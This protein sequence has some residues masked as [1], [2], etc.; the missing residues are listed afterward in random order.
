MESGQGDAIT[1]T[2]MS[3]LKVKNLQAKQKLEINLSAA[4]L[5]II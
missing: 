4:T 2:D 3:F 5:L 1:E